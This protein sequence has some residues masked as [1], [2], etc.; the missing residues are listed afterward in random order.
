MH[1]MYLRDFVEIS[2]ILDGTASTNSIRPTTNCQLESDIICM[3]SH[4]EI[5]FLLDLAQVSGVAHSSQAPCELHRKLWQTRLWPAHAEIGPPQIA[6]LV[7]HPAFQ[8]HNS[9]HTLLI[10]F[11]RLFTSLSSLSLCPSSDLPY[12]HAISCCC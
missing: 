2:F 7:S 1:I 9:Q 10:D 6:K 11:T 4:T 3:I 5:R 8:H 12:F